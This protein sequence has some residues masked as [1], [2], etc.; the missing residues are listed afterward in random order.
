VTH[1]A[2]DATGARASTKPAEG[3]SPDLH[4]CAGRAGRTTQDHVWSLQPAYSLASLITTAK[5]L[6]RPP[7][8]APGPGIARPR[9]VRSIPGPVPQGH[10]SSSAPSGKEQSAQSDCT[11]YSRSGPFGGV[12]VASQPAPWPGLSPCSSSDVSRI[13]GCRG[14]KPRTC[15]RWCASSPSP[16]L[17]SSFGRMHRSCR[18]RLPNGAQACYAAARSRGSSPRLPSVSQEPLLGGRSRSG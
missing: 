8:S 2:S 14:P 9:R 15:R 13:C 1:P 12:S 10:R 18:C 3:H 5:D 4:D 6:G 16:I 7:D 17:A 11:P